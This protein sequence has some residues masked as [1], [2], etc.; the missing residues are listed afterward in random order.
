MVDVINLVWQ[1]LLGVNRELIRL[2]LKID[3]LHL[4]AFTVVKQKVSLSTSIVPV[5]CSTFIIA[6]KF[7]IDCNQ[8]NL[9]VFSAGKVCRDKQIFCPALFKGIGCDDLTTK[10]QQVVFIVDSQ[11]N[12]SVL[13]ALAI[14]LTDA[15]EC[16]LEVRKSEVLVHIYTVYSDVKF[17]V[18]RVQAWI[19]DI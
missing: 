5:S 2:Y 8:F 6:S 1:L 19:C 17:V 13:F 16:V 7:L 9:D 12:R 10:C 11:F 15:V 4:V 3:Q 14:A 18:E